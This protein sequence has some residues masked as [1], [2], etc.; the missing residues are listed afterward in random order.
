MHI[1]GLE[2]QSAPHLPSSRASASTLEPGRVDRRVHHRHGILFPHQRR[3]GP[4]ARP[5]SASLDPWDA[6]TLEWMTADPAEHNFDDDPEVHSPRRVLA[7]QVRGGRGVGRFAQVA[8]A[9]EVM[10]AKRAPRRTSTCRRRPTGRSS[11]P[12]ACRSW[13]SGSSSAGGSRWSGRSSSC[14]ALYGWALE[15]RWRP[16]THD[17]DHRR[18]TSHEG[19]ATVE[20]H[21][22]RRRAGAVDGPRHGPRRRP[23]HGSSTHDHG[24]VEQQARH[25][26]VPRV[27][28]PA[29]RRADLHLPA[30]PRPHAG[31]PAAAQVFDIPFTSVQLVRPADELADDGAGGVGGQARRHP[32]HPPVAARHRAARRDLRRWPGLRVHHLLPRGPGLHDQPVRLGLLHAHRLPRRPRHASAS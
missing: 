5:R 16:R 28:V 15:P 11:S 21:R 20:R 2:G 9:E 10:A 3:A 19:A 17:D 14:S 24:P 32:P 6:R 23:A 7:P 8:T 12:S 26:A 29:V 22:G 25:V 4:S 13:L 1:V 31:G 30:L 18:P 27:R